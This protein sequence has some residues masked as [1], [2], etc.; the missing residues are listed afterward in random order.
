MA[1]IMRDVQTLGITPDIISYTSDY[2]PKTMEIME[3]MIKEGLC[4]A[5]DT[6]ADKVSRQF[7]L[8][9]NR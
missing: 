9:V 3:Q 1:N 4:Y 5:D 6:P 2:F 8:P 7:C